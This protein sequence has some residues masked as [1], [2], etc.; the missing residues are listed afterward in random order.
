MNITIKWK[1]LC[2]TNYSTFAIPAD[3]LIQYTRSDI[4]DVFTVEDVQ[5]FLEIVEK[6]S[7]EKPIRIERV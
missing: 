6:I 3:T 4:D 1:P 7:Q 2:E 5:T